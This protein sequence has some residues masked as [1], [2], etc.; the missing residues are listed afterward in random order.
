VPPTYPPWPPQQGEWAELPEELM[1]LV[2][3][4]LDWELRESAVVRLTCLRWRNIPDGGCKTL[5]LCYRAT[6]EMVGALC[7]RLPALTEMELTS[8]SLTDEGLGVVA[9][10]TS[11]THLSLALCLK[12][13]GEGL[14]AAAGITS[15]TQ[16]NLSN[17]P[18]VTDKGLRAVAGLTGLTDLSLDHCSMVTD[19]GLSAVAALTSLTRLDLAGCS[20]VTGITVAGL[21]SLAHLNLAGC[22]KVTNEGL[23]TVAGLT[24]LTELN[25]SSSKLT[26]VVL[27]R[28]SGLKQLKFLNLSYC[29]TSKAAEVA[30]CRQIPGLV[31]VH[32]DSSEE[33]ESEGDAF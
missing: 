13:S 1:L 27:R 14:A 10:L 12:V 28:L 29:D 33:E 3:D 21:A 22:S 18:K 24:S 16:L 19:K 30:L 17:C 6:D 7:A 15:L 32:E 20:K 5:R 23:R 9:G 25:L 11:L 26:D 4:R 2:L 31:I 8:R